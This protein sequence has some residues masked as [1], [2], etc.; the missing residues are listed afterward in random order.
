MRER[1]ICQKVYGDM[2]LKI[3]GRK[4][5]KII[6][7]SCWVQKNHPKSLKNQNIHNLLKHMVH[8]LVQV[9]NCLDYQTIKMWSM[10]K[11]KLMRIDKSTCSVVHVSKSTIEPTL[12]VEVGAGVVQMQVKYLS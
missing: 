5:E 8:P 4:K 9:E 2:K 6:N 10:R 12:E 11:N 1:S 3:Y 7:Y